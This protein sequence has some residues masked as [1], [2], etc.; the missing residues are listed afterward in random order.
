MSVEDEKHIHDEKLDRL[1]SPQ[2]LD[3]GVGAGKVIQ[4]VSR[5]LL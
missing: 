1:Q 2:H 3:H 5:S 4:V